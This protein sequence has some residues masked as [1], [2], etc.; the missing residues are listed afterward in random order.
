VHHK[1]GLNPQKEEWTLV[2]ISNVCNVC[3]YIYVHTIQSAEKVNPTSDITYSLTPVAQVVRRAS[4]AV[5]AT[6]YMLQATCYMVACYLG[7]EIG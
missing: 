5:Q 1:H 4:A 6:C 2:V 3:M 7:D